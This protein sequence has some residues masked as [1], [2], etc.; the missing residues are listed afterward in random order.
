LKGV[1]RRAYTERVGAYGWMGLAAALVC[2]QGAMAAARVEVS[3][4][5][6]TVEAPATVTTGG[7]EVA[8][9]VDEAACVIYCTYR[10]AGGVTLLPPV[11][12][13]RIFGDGA[14]AKRLQIR[15][16]FREHSNKVSF[17]SFRCRG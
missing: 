1:W 4:G 15:D 3:I 17:G 5:A 11:A 16:A 6:V 9:S 14:A 2:A 10:K 7:W 13:L 12:T 8:V